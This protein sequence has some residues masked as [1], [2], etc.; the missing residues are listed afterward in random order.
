MSEPRIL[1]LRSQRPLPVGR[2]RADALFRGARC[3]EAGVNRSSVA[4]GQS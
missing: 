4:G 1:F 3:Q 2:T